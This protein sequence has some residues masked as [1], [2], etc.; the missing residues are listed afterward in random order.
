MMLKCSYLLWPYNKRNFPSKIWLAS[1]P[2]PILVPCAI[3]VYHLKYPINVSSLLHNLENKVLCFKSKVEKTKERINT[4]TSH[5]DLSSRR[6]LLDM[7]IPNFSGQSRTENCSLWNP[8]AQ[9]CSHECCWRR[10]SELLSAAVSSFGSAR[11][12][13]SSTQSFQNKV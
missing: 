4:R 6:R 13:G 7:E 12:C 5:S 11:S 3:Q 10:Q 2:S 1:S 9:H 8:A